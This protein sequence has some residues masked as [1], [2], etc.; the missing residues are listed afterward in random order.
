M[1]QL[2]LTS[3]TLQRA[4]LSDVAAG[5]N[6][7]GVTTAGANTRGVTTAGANTR[8][9]ASTVPPFGARLPIHTLDYWTV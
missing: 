5:G 1:L 4:K 9:V 7:R 6:T 8:G 3:P 2:K